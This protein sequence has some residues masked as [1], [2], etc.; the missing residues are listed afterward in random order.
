[1]FG[2]RAMTLGPTKTKKDQNSGTVEDQRRFLTLL[3]DAR[4]EAL[5]CGATVEEVGEPS[6]P[7]IAFWTFIHLMRLLQTQSLDRSS[8]RFWIF[9]A[10]H[11]A[12]PLR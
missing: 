6:S 12:F 10:P 1:M 11:H 7:G 5:H 3:E 8:E 2:Q 9:A 4:K